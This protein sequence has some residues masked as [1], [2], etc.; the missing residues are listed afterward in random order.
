[1]G[2]INDIPAGF[3]ICDGNNGTL[4]LIAR[5]PKGVATAATDPGTTGTVASGAGVATIE[6]VPL[7]KI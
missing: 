2:P 1:M 3:V 6:L 7:M 5:L 4:N